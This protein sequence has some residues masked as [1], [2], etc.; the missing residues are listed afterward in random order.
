MTE[1]KVHALQNRDSVQLTQLTIPKLT[2]LA[3]EVA[4]RKETVETGRLRISKQTHAREALIDETLFEEHA[5]IERVPI[6]RQIFEMPSIRHE[7]ETTIVPIVEEVLHTERRLILKEEVRITRRRTNEQFRDQVTL[8]YQEAVI[9][10]VQGATEQADAA[11]AKSMEPR[12]QKMTYEALVAVYDTPGHADAAVKA[13]KAAG[14]AESDISVFDEA[15][16][17]AGRSTLATG[18]KEAGLWHRLFGTDVYQHE[19]NIYGETVEDG[20]VVISVRVP[21]NEVAHATALLDIHRPV[22]VHDPR[23]Y[24]WRGT[25]GACRG[26]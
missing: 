17:K 4:V 1:S 10:R 16:L 23:G 11:S 19:A 13:L 20:G 26:D 9:T 5:E 21:P 2:L 25:R 14:F 8:R 15:R 7:G 24:E 6:G 3:E 18:V 22:D 12:E